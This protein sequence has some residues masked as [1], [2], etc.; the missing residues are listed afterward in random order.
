MIDLVKRAQQGDAE[1]YA[2]LIRI[3]QDSFYRIARSRTHND[4][5]AADAIQEA[6]LA[7]WEK[8]MTLKNPKFFKTWM[9]RILINKCNEIFRKSP[10]MES[11][12]Q[13]PEP[14]AEN[15]EGNLMFQAMLQELS[16]SNRL[17]MALYYGE[18]YSVREIAGILEIS[19]NAV[20][21]RL[22]RGRKEIL[23]AYEN[24]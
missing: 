19:E 13:V 21:Q 2:G 14:Q 18:D 24:E 20:K 22:S 6:L 4:E 1:A 15:A 8:R 10:P 11:L 16:E 9:I 3:Y 7:G 12:E 23:K 17:V 5:D